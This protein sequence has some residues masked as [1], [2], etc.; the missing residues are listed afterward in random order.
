MRRRVG[1]VWS[2]VLTLAL[3]AG[4]AGAAAAEGS[5]YSW[6]TQ[7]GSYAFTDDAK[8]I[9]PRYREQVEVRQNGA[10]ADY[11][12]FTPS[13]AA[14]DRRYA[15]RL[16]ERL[17]YLRS[18]NA[19][20][21]RR[22]PAGAVNRSGAPRELVTLRS[23]SSDTSGVDITTPAGGGR[24]PIVVE[25]VLMREPGKIV[26]QNVQITRRGDR[27]IAITKPRSRE[28]NVSDVLDARDLKKE[29][30]QGE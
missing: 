17:D 20:L 19:S 25:T 1:G 30:E 8:S 28:W 2:G 7:D 9:P 12:R 5:I 3:L 21:P 6:R 29:I 23:G 18:L 13:D 24:A 14:A 27:V 15:E 10:L 11:E 26:T 4:G 22:S 16:S